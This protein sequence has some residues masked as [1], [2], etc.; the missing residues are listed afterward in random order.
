MVN[1]NISA[2]EAK[3]A[4]QKVHHSDYSPGKSILIPISEGIGQ[5]RLVPYKADIRPH[6]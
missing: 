6:A 3:N 1:I 4:D 5:I 2:R